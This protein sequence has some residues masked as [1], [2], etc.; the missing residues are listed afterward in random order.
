MAIAI[1]LHQDL[2]CGQTIDPLATDQNT[3]VRR[4]L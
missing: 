2:V 3:A 4:A 1:P